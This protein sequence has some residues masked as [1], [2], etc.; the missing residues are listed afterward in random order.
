MKTAISQRLDDLIAV[1][2]QLQTILDA[3]D[4]R[5]RRHAAGW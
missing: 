2:R 5:H 1:A 4:A 3:E